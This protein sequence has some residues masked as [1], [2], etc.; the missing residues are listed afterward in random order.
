MLTAAVFLFDALGIRPRIVASGSMAPVILPGD[1]VF[2][3]ENDREAAA[4]DVI[5]YRVRPAESILPET[6]T[7]ESAP[8]KSPAKEGIFPEPR[9]ENDFHEVL[10]RLV[11]ENTDG[12]LVTKGDANDSP[13]LTVVHREDIA[14]K[15]MLVIPKLGM[16]DR[17]QILCLLIGLGLLHLAFIWLHSTS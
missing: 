6:Q 13:D 1:V 15:L 3:N 14:G 16:L 2:I 12:T 11:G 17:A 8:A 10:H 4:G 9:T 7:K 5:L